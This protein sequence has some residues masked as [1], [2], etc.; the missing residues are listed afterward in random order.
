MRNV[1]REN[2]LCLRIR[3]SKRV[4]S[5]IIRKLQMTIRVPTGLTVVYLLV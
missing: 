5:D 1:S 2:L 3:P 4:P